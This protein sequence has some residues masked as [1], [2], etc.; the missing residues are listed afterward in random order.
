MHE[1][2]ALPLPLPARHEIGTPSPLPPSH[3]DI[4]YKLL[5]QRLDRAE[6]GEEEAE[7]GQTSS[8][9]SGSLPSSSLV[10]LLDLSPIGICLYRI[11]N[12]TAFKIFGGF[13]VEVA[14][15]SVEILTH[16]PL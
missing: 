9:F 7:L 16:I 14:Y 1:M 11:S 5:S 8:G 4:P 13:F 3:G 10:A 15:R 6:G 2:P 12:P